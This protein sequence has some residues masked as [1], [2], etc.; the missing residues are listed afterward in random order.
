M[1]TALIL[2]VFAMTI[3]VGVRYL[4]V[5]GA[6]AWLTDRR[7]PGF[8]D[9]RSDQIRK[10][11][12]WSLAS[13]FIYAAPAGLLAWGW[14]ARGWTRIYADVTDYPLWWLPGSVAVCLLLHDSWFYWTHRF[15]H[16]PRIYKRMHA[17]HHASRNPTAWAAMSFHP[18]ESIMGAVLV[19]SLV[20]LIPIHYG[21]LLAVLLIMTVMGVTNHMG[22]ELF[23][24][25]LVRGPTGR[26]LI[27]ASHHQR[28]HEKH[29]CNYGLY[30]RFW[31]RLCGTDRGLGEFMIDPSP[32][33]LR[34]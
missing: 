30:F 32:R 29:L 31:D 13:A 19:P 3:I 18:W 33:P 8:Y 21:A 17:V 14:Q 11:I 20:L 15:M 22:W 27:T 2:S 16:R 24:N 12:G 10:E 25:W 6:F 9:D 5:S 28:H 4:A 34:N 1:L 7:L 26:W 23:P